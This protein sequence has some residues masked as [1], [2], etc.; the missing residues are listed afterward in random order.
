MKTFDIN[1]FWQMLKWNILTDEMSV[2]KKAIIGVV[3]FLIIQAFFCFNLFDLTASR[4]FGSTLVGMNLCFASGGLFTLFYVS[5]MLG[6]ARTKEQRNIL[7]MMP[8]SNLEKYASRFLYCVI[9]LPLLLLACLYVATGIRMLLELILGHKD[10]YFGMS[11]IPMITNQFNNAQFIDNLWTISVFVLGGVL[12]K[13][14]PFLWTWV[15]IVAI[16]IALG[17]VVALIAISTMGNGPLQMSVNDNH[18]AFKAVLAALT[19]FNFWYSYRLFCRLQL[20]TRKWF[21][22]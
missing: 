2:M 19:V 1:R 10:I 18:W 6:N 11:G 7:L 12:F 9:L 20:V 15:S 17:L 5:G 8:A 4:G 21:N 3:A 22:L 16:S 14:N 13:K